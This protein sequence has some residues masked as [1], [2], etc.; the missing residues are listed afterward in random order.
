M[1]KRS[2]QLSQLEMFIDSINRI[3]GCKTS[4]Y[5]GNL[6]PISVKSVGLGGGLCI[7]YGCN[8]CSSKQAELKTYS[9]CEPG[10]RTNAISLSVQVAFILAG[11]THAVYTKTLS[12]ALG[13][14]SVSDK[15]FF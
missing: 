9:R 3:R 13:M 4:N 1:Q 11:C 12:H 5:D 14:K 8:G 7:R 6:V 2:V 15:V 10:R